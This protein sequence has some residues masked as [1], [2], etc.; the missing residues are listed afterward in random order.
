M[1][2][3]GSGEEALDKLV[4]G[5]EPQLIVILSDTNNMP[6]MDGL[7]LLGGD[8]TAEPGPAIMMVTAYRDDDR[9]R[10]A[11]KYGAVKF[12][13]KPADFGSPNQQLRQLPQPP[14]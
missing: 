8:Q 6:G 13:T 2:F 10:L 14:V 12:I 5:I 3:A 7:T 11:G 1:H 9:R 4:T